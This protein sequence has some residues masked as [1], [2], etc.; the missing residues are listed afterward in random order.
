MVFKIN[1]EKC[2]AASANI[3]QPSFITHVDVECIIVFP[4]FWTCCASGQALDS[5]TIS[6]VIICNIPAWMETKYLHHLQY[7]HYGVNVAVTIRS[8]TFVRQI[9]VDFLNEWSIISN[10]LL[11]ILYQNQFF[12][13]KTCLLL[14]LLMN[15][16]SIKLSDILS[17]EDDNGK[18]MAVDKQFFLLFLYFFC[19]IRI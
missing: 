10:T 16:I 2:S 11:W 9:Y 4:R 13:I 1:A 3:H 19:V 17:D 6:C 14:W 15:I 8:A 5:R 7:Q 12:I 18:G